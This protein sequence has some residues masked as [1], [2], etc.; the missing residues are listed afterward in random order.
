FNM[1]LKVPG[2]ADYAETLRYF[3][4]QLALSQVTLKLGHRATAEDLTGGAFDEVVIATGVTPRLPDLPGIDHPK[5]LSYVDVLQDARPV[6]RRVAIIGAGG[7]GFD[8]AEFLVQ[9]SEPEL[10]EFMAEWGVDQGYGERGG[11]LAQ[12]ALATPIRE[13]TL[14]QR[15][16][17]K[18]GAGLGKSTGWIHRS[19]LQ[20][21]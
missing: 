6:G 15:K 17:G 4:R 10:A 21:K 13:I 12:P 9:E 14:L 1:A 11:L 19:A 20:M 3:E 2:K 16:A 5:V 8:V 7:I 18:P